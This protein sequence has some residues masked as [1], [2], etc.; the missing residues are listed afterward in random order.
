MSR[1]FR[2]PGSDKLLRYIL[3]L[4]PARARL[5][6]LLCAALVTVFLIQVFKPTFNNLEERIGA[7]GWTLS[8]DATPEQRIAI[9]AID[10]RSLAEV[11][12]WPWDR[13]TMAQLVTAIDQAGA[14][15]QLHD[16]VYP[17]SR[18]GDQQFL[19]ALQASRGTVLAQMP[20]LQSSDNTRTGL[21][22]HPLSGINCQAM[23]GSGG[24]T[25]S[26]I[27]SER[28]F[29]S[30]PKGHI[31]ALI[32]SD[33]A[34]RMAPAFSCVDGQ[35]YPAL[36]LTAFLASHTAEQWSAT[37]TTPDSWFG[38]AQQLQ[39]DNYPGL[40]IPLD[41]QGNMRISFARAPESFRAISAADVLNGSP[42]AAI[43]DNAWV[44][45][46]G[47]AFGMGDIV[48]TPY[49]GATPGVEL[50]A[51]LLASLLD[52]QVP[53]TPRSSTWLLLLLCVAFSAALF[54]MARAREKLVAIG[55]P[56]AAILM[57]S[58]ALAIHLQSLA[59]L[60]IW[61][62][63]T[64]PAL[65][66]LIAASLLLLLELSRVR[67][68]RGRVFNNL[69]SYLPSD[70]ARE[71]AFSLPNSDVSARRCDV[72]LLNADLRNFS[73][74]GEARPPEE[75]AAILHYFFT[76]AT[77][78]VEHHGGRIHEFKGDGLLAIW[79][80]HDGQVAESA[81]AA[82]SELQLAIEGGFLAE[83][84]T[85]SL[86]PLGLGI[87]IEQG[88]VLVGSLGPAH[89]RSHTLLGDTVA[90]TLRIQEMTAELAQPILIGECAARQLASAKL[91]SQGSYL[92]A[93]LRTPHTLYAPRPD[94]DKQLPDGDSAKP[95]L[96]VLAGGRK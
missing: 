80:G 72:T 88:P 4:A 28:A 67:A 23:A 51:R 19:Q 41:E 82:A 8:A 63:W 57:P 24:T 79:D 65:Y 43:L 29:A 92:L 30:I 53:Y 73:A 15:L 6:A 94:T 71:I 59:S 26:F 86:E 42:D 3:E 16:I 49:N 89:R 84:D 77:E 96:R 18:P 35:P 33:G 74:F 46:G 95:A 70:I 36:A 91:Q 37:L 34:V 58:L 81:F 47:S 56:A 22:T 90:I 20:L 38:P 76:K 69:S 14:Q 78:I 66:S 44:L 52:L 13:Q 17:E 61:L 45:V 93:G 10:E 50:Q 83:H 40:D 27:A 32:A 7:L 55:L 31:S 85:S 68:E 9:V 11:G 75:S 12:P 5:L 2:I 1:A 21:M 25:N 60:N 64:V 87:G 39:L 54:V 48:P 62:G